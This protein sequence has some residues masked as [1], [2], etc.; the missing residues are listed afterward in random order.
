MKVDLDGRVKNLDLPVSKPLMPLLEAIT[1]S[2]HSI[3]DSGI[4]DGKITVRILRDKDDQ[5]MDFGPGSRALDS[6]IGFQIDDNGVGFN[7]PNFV[8]FET[9]DSRHKVSRGAKGI[10]RLLWLKAFGKIQIQSFYQDG[11]EMRRRRF[12]FGLPGG[13]STSE[14]SHAESAV[15]S[16]A[17]VLLTEWL[18]D[19]AKNCPKKAI[20]IADYLINHLILSLLNPSAPVIEIVDDAE[21][22]PINLNARFRER[23]HEAGA[24][25]NLAIGDHSFTLHHFRVTTPEPEK[26]R[27]QLVA[28]FRE[29]IELKLAERFPALRSKLLDD[30]S[31]PF[32]YLGILSGP[33]LDDKVNQNRTGFDLAGAGEI[34]IEGEPTQPEVEEAATEATLRHLAPYLQGIRKTTTERVRSC[35]HEEFPEYRPLLPR[36]VDRIDQFSPTATPR[37]I[38]RRINEIQLEEELVTKQEGDS[39]QKNEV[40]TSDDYRIR[41]QAFLERVTRESE[42]RLAQYV[43]HRRVILELLEERLKR[44]DD[45]KYP[46]EEE[47]HE[48]IFP[49]KATSDDTG[50][51]GHQNLWLVDERLAYHYW[52]ASDKPLKSQEPIETDS[53]ERPDL[54]IMNRP[55][56]F[57]PSDEDVVLSSVTLVEL[58][59]PGRSSKGSDRRNPIEQLFDY[60]E[61]I[62]SNKVKDANGRPIRVDQGTAFFAYLICDVDAD[63]EYDRMTRTHG[64]E[65]TPDALGFFAFNKP[66]NTYLEVITFDKLV[67]DAKRRNRVLFKNLGIEGRLQRS[68]L[69][70]ALAEISAA[71]EPQ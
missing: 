21:E 27:L 14:Q 71:S 68:E 39:L 56:A 7:D 65:P 15:A 8:S 55:G 20:T 2:L 46:L 28:S 16:G 29:V 44:R 54:L 50:V 61:L 59:R 70:A 60:V 23:F 19:Y 9:C 4:D 34:T 62:R 42:A 45:E 53:A 30:E 48:L 57:S 69:D 47:V 18:E 17:T 35:V 63:S 25:E 43:T 67:Q 13:V 33:L 10:G 49:L 22:Q 3:E 66:L 5:A 6:I 38:L 24:S 12:S 51:W 31:H 36:I 58:K 1:N 32:A 41:Y 26:H 64:L 11:G 37:E 52:L 40:K